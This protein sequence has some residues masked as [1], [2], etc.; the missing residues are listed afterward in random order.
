MVITIGNPLAP[1]GHETRGHGI[2]IDNIRERLVY[3]FGA[4]AQ[5]LT[6]RDEEQFYAVMVV[7]H[8]EHTDR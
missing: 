5:L 3:A 7:P 2:A 1:K 4:R 6:N 8:V